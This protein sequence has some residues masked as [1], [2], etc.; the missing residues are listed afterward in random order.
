VTRWPAP[1]STQGRFELYR[2][3]AETLET[4]FA[5]DVIEYFQQ[6][7]QDAESSHAG[8]VAAQKSPRRW[9]RRGLT[10]K[11]NGKLCAILCG[12]FRISQSCPNC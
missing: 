4:K 8:L 9:E 3:L 10:T 1:G 5:D 2:A 12:L 6:A 7:L 11:S